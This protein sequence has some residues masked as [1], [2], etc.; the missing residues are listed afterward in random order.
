MARF[1][2]W[3]SKIRIGKRLIVSPKRSV[4]LCHQRGFSSAV[5]VEKAEN[6]PRG[7]SRPISEVD[8]G[9]SKA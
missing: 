5:R 7:N 6:Q 3:V 9:P 2:R 1:V 4:L 8:E